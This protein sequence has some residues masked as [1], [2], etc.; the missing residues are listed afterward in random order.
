MG[1]ELRPSRAAGNG[2]CSS[3]RSRSSPAVRLGFQPELRGHVRSKPCLGPAPTGGYP[4]S[5][6]RPQR[7]SPRPGAGSTELGPERPRRSCGHPAE[8]G[9]ARPPP[10]RA[11]T[12][13]PSPAIGPG[14]AAA[15]NGRLAPGAA[16]QIF[17]PRRPPADSRAA[18]PRPRFSSFVTTRP[19]Q[20]PEEGRGHRVKV[21]GPLGLGPDAKGVR[22]PGLGH[23]A[24]AAGGTP[25]LTS[26]PDAARRKRRCFCSHW[27]VHLSPH[28]CVSPG[29]TDGTASIN[30]CRTNR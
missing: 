5:R 11:V 21:R 6:P 24:L 20:L 14:R 4:T 7:P 27:A 29:G 1:R 8:H 12:S 15:A 16:L 28:F 30:A 18:A 9:P 22:S 19:E 2:G 3:L 26:K 25:C 23:G 13:P 17:T 10:P